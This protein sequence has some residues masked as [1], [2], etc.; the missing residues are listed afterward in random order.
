MQ[1]KKTGVAWL[2]VR[3]TMPT[4]IF[5]VSV[6]IEQLN[7]V[8]YPVRR[9]PRLKNMIPRVQAT[10]RHVVGSGTWELKLSQVMSTG[11]NGF[12]LY[13]NNPENPLA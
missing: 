10:S 5:T 8:V 9:I 1:S 3:R 4:P 13:A 6:D 12:W 7:D 11:G 2:S